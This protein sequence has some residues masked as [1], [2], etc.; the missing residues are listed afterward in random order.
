MTFG[1]GVAI[2]WHGS[3]N[4]VDMKTFSGAF[5]F[6]TVIAL[7]ITATAH[8]LDNPAWGFLLNDNLRDMR[9]K[10]LETSSFIPDQDVMQTQITF[11]DNFMLKAGADS[12]LDQYGHYRFEG[13]SIIALGQ[14]AHITLPA[15][16]NAPD[17][18]LNA[19]RE[20]DPTSV[21]G[22][23]DFPQIAKDFTPYCVVERGGNLLSEQQPPRELLLA[24]KGKAYDLELRSFYYLDKQDNTPVLA[25]FGSLGVNHGY[26]STTEAFSSFHCFAPIKGKKPK[27]LDVVKRIFGNLAAIKKTKGEQAQFEKIEDTMHAKPAPATIESNTPAPATQS[28]TSLNAQH[29]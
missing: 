19:L 28:G 23:D 6:G 9:G 7:S 22:D 25:I 5:L 14:Q 2:T 8:A 15:K 27:P 17:A 24:L 11:K 16:P 3:G 1:E 13:E 4:V 26:V 21:D 20:I 12:V 18:Q 29:L 10:P